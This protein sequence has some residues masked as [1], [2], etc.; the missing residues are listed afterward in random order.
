MQNNER[1]GWPSCEMLSVP[2]IS[3]KTQFTLT[4]KSE[5]Y[6]RAQYTSAK[7]YELQIVQL[8]A[9]SGNDVNVNQL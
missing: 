1:N 3:L 8:F 4:E 2:H 5:K 9:I 7:I 6:G